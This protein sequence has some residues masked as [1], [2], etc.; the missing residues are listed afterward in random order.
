MKKA[1]GRGARWLSP[2]LGL[3]P[4]AA[5]ADASLA[6]ADV[7]ASWVQYAEHATGSVSSWLEGEDTAAVDLRT[8]IFAEGGPGQVEQP[9]VVSLWIE[10]DR[11]SDVKLRAAGY[12][13]AESDL[14]AFLVGRRLQAA[15]PKDMRQPINMALEP[16]D[17]PTQSAE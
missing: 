7:P 10:G 13:Q 1:L 2:L 6:P 14:K 15:A 16:G 4:V 9:L 17:A 8:R 3:L 12:A 11:V 5:M